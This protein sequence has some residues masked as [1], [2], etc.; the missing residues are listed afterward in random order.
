[1]I[2]DKQLIDGCLFHAMPFCLRHCSQRECALHYE[3]LASSKSG[4]YQCPHG[5][6]SYVALAS[7]RQYIFTGLRV[8][9]YYNKKLAS[10]TQ[11][12]ENIYNPVIPQEEFLGV[13]NETINMMEERHSLQKKDTAVTDLLHETRKLNGQIKNICD[14]VWESHADELPDAEALL[15]IVRN[16]HVSSYLIYN[17]FQQLDNMLNP[18]LSFGEPTKAVIF[19][20][21]DKM[22]KLLRG[23]NRKNVWI[24]I[25]SPTTS[26]F[27]YNTYPTFETLLFILFENGIK[28]SPN[29][30]PINVTF[31]E[32]NSHTLDVKI[33]SYGPLCSQ[34]EVLKLGTRGF[35][36]EN[37][38]LYDSTGQGLGLNFAKKICS[39]HNI[40]ISF[41]SRYSHKDHGIK[42]GV[43]TIQ[44]HFDADKQISNV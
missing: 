5:M 40:D 27:S 22:R 3:M 7:N 31:N 8:H 30:K 19:K 35:R 36:S 12:K 24:S 6:T 20:K 34:E 33:E 14:I 4:F 43:F 18:G 2:V 39:K 42:Y 25:N 41:S 32:P 37:A 1:M 23:Y 28:Y 9:G 10:T 15:E 44:L 21:I 38:K 17:R 26:N 29:N 11:A 16:I 13:V